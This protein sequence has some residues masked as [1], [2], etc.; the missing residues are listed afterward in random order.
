MT[1]SSPVTVAQYILDQQRIHHPRASGDFSWLLCGIT[2]S[3]KVVAAQVRRAGLSNILGA[4]GEINVQGEAQQKLDVFA[5]QALLHALGNR[6]NVGVLASEENEEP[7]VVMANPDHG[8]YIVVFDPL[9]GSSNIDLNVSVGTIFSIFRRDKNNLSDPASDV[10]QPGHKQIAAGYVLYGSST[11]MVY[12]TGHGVH[13]FTLDL[14]IG[15]FVL[16]H[17]NIT[18]PG[19]GNLYSVNEANADSFPESY[20]RYLHWLKSSEDGTVYSSRYIG[21]LVADFHRT[22][23]KGG[24]FLYPLAL[25]WV[26]GL[27][28]ALERFGFIMRVGAGNR[29]MWTQIQPLLEAGKFREVG[30]AVANSE[31]ALAHIMRYGIS[32]I[33]SA[34]R[35]DDIEKALEESLVEVIPRLE[36]RTHYL[37]SLANIGMLMGLLGTIIGLIGA[38]AAVAQANPAEKASLL[39]ASISVAMNNTALGL[40][41]AITLLL[42]H[43]YLETKTTEIVDSLEV[44]S[45]KFLNALN[46]KRLDPEA[47]QDAPRAPAAAGRPI[48]PGVRGARA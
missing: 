37:S 34:R 36:K 2:L 8:E 40:V 15:A 39:A 35:R 33:Q 5:N 6:G 47:Q 30:N 12:T 22:M 29:R 7:V 13:G 14:S 19:R 25:I 31:T 21:S 28:I 48:E 16:S 26:I 32:R 9:D 45:V 46:E 44:A 4:A 43:L 42:A 23:L 41:T 38:F 27:V 1:P 17:P 20:R 3:A 11:M 24:I 18:M 10:L